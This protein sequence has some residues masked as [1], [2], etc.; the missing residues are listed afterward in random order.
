MRLPI[1][2]I[3]EICRRP[4]EAEA[5]RRWERRA[6]GCSLIALSIVALMQPV[7]TYANIIRTTILAGKAEAATTAQMT[8]GTTTAIYGT[9]TFTS[10]PLS[11]VGTAAGF[12]TS[13]GTGGAITA[14]FSG[15]FGILAK[16][17]FG[18]AGDSGRY[19]STYSPA[20]YSIKFT[21]TAAVKGINYV[22]IDITAL[23][24]GNEL[25]V[26]RNGVV[27]QTFSASI[28]RTALGTCP[29]TNNPYCGNP[30]TGANAG[31]QYA[32]VNIFDVSGYFDELRLKQASGG[33]FEADNITVGFREVNQVF[34][35]LI[36]VPTPASA[37]LLAPGLLALA[38]VR[39]RT[40]R[41]AA[42]WRS[43]AA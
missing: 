22:G 15:N 23:D 37:L 19:I 41:A 43:G 31:E 14:A 33:G 16:D 1:G 5:K 29:N 3:P 34:G 38:M 26:L 21:H 17:A 27:L 13:F 30:V 11:A 40:S 10:R 28:L 32:Y 20:G 8:T 12:S 25:T 18:G 4:E 35:Q 2:Y 24:N 36:N 39:R 6:I 9:E 7:V 42:G